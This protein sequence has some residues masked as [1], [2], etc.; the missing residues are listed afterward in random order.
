MASGVEPVADVYEAL[1][2]AA[3]SHK[4]YTVATVASSCS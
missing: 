1:K 4:K 3:D 2:A